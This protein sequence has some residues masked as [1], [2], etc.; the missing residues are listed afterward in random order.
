M[1]SIRR[2]TAAL[3]AALSMASCSA[4]EFPPEELIE[5]D[6]PL[7]G[8]VTVLNDPSR[9][10]TA[11]GEQAR[12]ELLVASP[13]PQAAWTYAMKVCRHARSTGSIEVCEPSAEI[14]GATNGVTMAQPPDQLPSVAFTAPAEEALAADEREL[15]VQGLI[16]P[17]GAL[18]ASVLAAYEANTLGAWTGSL[19][20]CEDKSR[21]GL[22]IS[23]L[24]QLE[25][26]P[27][28]RNRA[29]GI[30]AVAFS[31]PAMENPT[32][33]GTSWT[34]A[35]PAELATTGCRGTG[36][37]E[38][39]ASKDLL[40]IQIELAANARETYV[41]RD[42]I[43]GEPSKQRTEVPNVEGFASAGE[44]EIVR[45]NQQ[46][47][48]QLLQLTWRPPKA[49]VDPSGLPVRFWFVASDD[50]RGATQTSTW[51]LRALCLVPQ[52]SAV[53]ASA[54]QGK[55]GSAFVSK[56]VVPRSRS[57]ITAASRPGPRGGL[58]VARRSR[59]AAPA[60]RAARRAR[61]RAARR[62]RAARSRA[63][64]HAPTAS[65]AYL[66]RA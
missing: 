62:A 1:R 52:A 55:G 23:A 44:F 41:E 12:Y 28:D 34:S 45:D 38:L 32:Q 11:P 26:S 50:R 7:A 46:R 54:T 29:P 30:A 25:R 8:H 43:T 49:P 48:G 57:S 5:K 36:M 17:G 56:A 4:T 42:E 53:S 3:C 14:V 27:G 9:A 19:N 40:G 6:R 24:V 18:D 16:C 35:A 2:T 10:T 37:P 21:N 51:A 31:T 63:A 20:A 60:R 65:T 61:P 47:S 58:R 59:F 66:A 39:V 13:G 33:L 15:L 22:L 64:R